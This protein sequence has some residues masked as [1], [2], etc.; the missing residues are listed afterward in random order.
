MPKPCAFCPND[1]VEHGGEHVWDNWLNKALPKSRYRA[2]KQYSNDSPLIE[3]DTHSLDEKLPVVCGD[4]NSGWMSVL[5]QKVKDRFGHAML[6]GEP[7]SL[8]ATDA[9]I[10]ASF[11]FMK[12]VVTNHINYSDTEPFF[13]RGARERFRNSLA[14][15]PSTK[16]WFAAFRGQSRMSTRNNLSL[17]GTSNPGPLF[18][19]EFCSF[20]HVVGRLALQ[21]L[22]PRWKNINHRGRPLVSLTPN[23]LWEPATTLFWPHGGD[24]LSWPPSKYLGDNMINAFIERFANRV[25]LPTP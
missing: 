9:A 14:I 6:N 18:G 3:Y 24:V 25:D 2:R 10:L 22:A 20:T 16:V 19:I 8:G 13:T 23:L 17:I 1:A 21:L 12:A 5:T 4:C 15:P 7:F 11:T